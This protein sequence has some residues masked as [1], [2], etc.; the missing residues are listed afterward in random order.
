[1]DKRKIK[2]PFYEKYNPVELFIWRNKKHFGSFLNRLMA[3]PYGSRNSKW[4]Y[5][6]ETKEF[7]WNQFKQLDKHKWS[8]EPQQRR[9]K[10]ER[11]LCCKRNEY[12]PMWVEFQKAVKET[13]E[14]ANA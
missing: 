13:K 11:L 14:R 8:K 10:A 1:M 9:M 6:F 4:K 12:N 7:V 2:I 3:R 5:D